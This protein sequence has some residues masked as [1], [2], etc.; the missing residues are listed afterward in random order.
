M[1][2]FISYS[3]Q[4]TL[5]VQNIIQTLKDEFAHVEFWWD[6]ELEKRGGKLWRN[7]LVTEIH[8]SDVFI[9]MMSPASNQSPHCQEEIRWANDHGKPV[10]PLRIDPETQVPPSLSP[11]Q[12]VDVFDENGSISR[13]VDA[14]LRRY[15][16][17]PEPQAASSSGG[18]GNTV[19]TGDNYGQVAGGNIINET[20]PAQNEF[21]NRQVQ[22]ERNT[23]YTDKAMQNKPV[24]APFKSVSP[25]IY[26]IVAG[27]LLS[28]LV[29]T[30]SGNFQ[31][32]AGLF[33]IAILLGIARRSL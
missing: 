29:F 12:Y 8:T 9:F 10:V 30:L 27:I 28:G 31:T 15:F 25:L 4:D 33:V 19:S 24:E 1:K 23:E 16:A 13:N 32:G 18:A 11:Y 20:T 17:S 21:F 3:H 5:A 22:R 7:E 2:A 26:M 6:K 14:T